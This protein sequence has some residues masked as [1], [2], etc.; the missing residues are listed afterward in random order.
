[1]WCRSV[2]AAYVAQTPQPSRTKTKH[3][4]EQL[5]TVVCD[6]LD[7]M[8]AVEALAETSIE[9][10]ELEWMMWAVRRRMTCAIKRGGGVF[11]KGRSCRDRLDFEHIYLFLSPLPLSLFRF[12]SMQ[13]L[14]TLQCDSLQHV[15]FSVVEHYEYDCTS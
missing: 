2:T 3:E 12:Y 4:H 9:G 7:G 5:H 8:E 14:D 6:R 13:L 15:F 10:R 1:M 11:S